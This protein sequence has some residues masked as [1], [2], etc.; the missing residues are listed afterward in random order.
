MSRSAPS[1]L[2]RTHSVGHTSGVCT[3]REFPLPTSSIGN[4]INFQNILPLLSLRSRQASKH[5]QAPTVLRIIYSCNHVCACV[6]ACVF[7]CRRGK[8][9]RDS[10]TKLA[11]KGQQK[12]E[13]GSSVPATGVQPGKSAGCWG[14]KVNG[15]WVHPTSVLT[16]FSISDLCLVGAFCRCRCLFPFLSLP[17]ITVRQEKAAETSNTECTTTTIKLLSQLL[18]IIFGRRSSNGSKHARLSDCLSV[19]IVLFLLDVCCHGGKNSPEKQ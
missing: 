10:S 1:R 4:F 8:G 9:E 15:E 7:G 19:C 12:K 6:C 2:V 5:M 11:R 17:L 3:E 18:L 13:S 14:K 16:N